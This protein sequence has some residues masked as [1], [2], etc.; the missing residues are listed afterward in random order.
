M[1]H[2]RHLIREALVAL[3]Q[4][5]G[6]LAGARVYD[7]PADPRTEFPALS[8]RDA[9]EQQQ[10]LTLPAGADRTI[11]RLYLLDVDAEVL[12]AANYARTRD[13]LCAD[14]EA[15]FAAATIAGVKHIAPAGYFPL[16]GADT[17]RPTVIGRQRFEILYFTPQGAPA[18]AL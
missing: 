3:L 13:Q 12:Q 14:V 6:T 18:T 8:L 2:R 17:E 5:A 10:P 15:A 1:D 7:H 4:G 16:M 11:E 9:S